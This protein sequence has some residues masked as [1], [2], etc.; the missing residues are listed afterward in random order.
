MK[1]IADVLAG[2]KYRRGL[3][4]RDNPSAGVF[5]PEV[6]HCET[7][8]EFALSVLE[9][10]V[11]RFRPGCPKCWGEKRLKEKLSRAG[12]GDRFLDCTF[13]NYRL[14]AGARQGEVFRAF[15]EYFI[16]FPKNLKNGS[17]MMLCGSVGTGK[18]HLA[19]AGAIEL[20]LRKHSVKYLLVSKYLDSLWGAAFGGRSQVLQTL[21][22]YDLLFLDEFGRHAETK[23]SSD[24]IFELLNARY[25][26]QR[27][28]VL[29]TNLSRDALKTALGVAVYSRMAQGGGM[30]LE[31]DWGDY[32]QTGR[33]P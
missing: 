8:G 11:E 18:N 25:E 10:G 28:T 5:E 17:C 7:H 1:T 14:Q 3:T 19:A 26:M 13:E 9:D 29:M 12:F 23:S 22:S 4:P 33:A 15:K 21:A 27:P 6:G 24:A 30:C 20:I 2:A 16:N 31:F 32:R